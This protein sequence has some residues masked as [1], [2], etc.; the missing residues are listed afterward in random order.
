MAINPKARIPHALFD[1]DRAVQSNFVTFDPTEDRQGIRFVTNHGTGL[2][3]PKGSTK[4]Q[5][6]NG[7]QKARL[8]AT[9]R[10]YQKI[11][12]RLRLQ[13]DIR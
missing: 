2:S 10:T 11:D 6:M 8:A 7:F 1:P 9:V 12:T 13:G 3:R 4:A 5:D